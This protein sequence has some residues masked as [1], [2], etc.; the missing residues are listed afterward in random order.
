MPLDVDSVEMRSDASSLT[1]RPAGNHRQ[2]STGYLELIT[3]E[4]EASRIIHF[5]PVAVPGL[6]QTREYATAI[7]STTILH[8]VTD[9]EIE[10]Q[11]DVRMQRQRDIFHG[12]KAVR[13]IFIVEEYSIRRPVGT[14]ATMRTQLDHLVQMMEHP[15]VT[16][17]VLPAR[18]PPHP[19]IAGPFMLIRHSD[20]RTD[21]VLCLEGAMGNTV[22]RDRPDLRSGY[23]KL[24]ERLIANGRSE[25]AA[26]QAI[27]SLRSRLGRT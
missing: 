9:D 16:I 24:A 14:R 15:R 13:T 23:A 18:F 6:L 4:A 21:D 8:P 11:V 27:W 10:M 26:R 17:V 1:D 22:V 12:T 19:G 5:H 7:T 2:L 3:A 20:P 25:D